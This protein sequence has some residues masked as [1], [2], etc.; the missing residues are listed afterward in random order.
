[1]A[2]GDF[3]PTLLVFLCR[4]DGCRAPLV[5]TAGDD[6]D[7]T[8]TWECAK[9]HKNLIQL[10]R[11]GGRVEIVAPKKSESQ[12]TNCLTGAVAT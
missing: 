3:E 11:F 9:G 6:D 8:S 7:G 1:M 12:A 2:Y 10:H 5:Q 4:R